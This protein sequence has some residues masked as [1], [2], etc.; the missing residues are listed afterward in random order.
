MVSRRVKAT[1]VSNK[2]TTAVCAARPPASVLYILEAK[3]SDEQFQKGSDMALDRR[4][5]AFIVVWVFRG[6]AEVFGG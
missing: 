3:M 4:L 5:F 1:N 2:M 6:S